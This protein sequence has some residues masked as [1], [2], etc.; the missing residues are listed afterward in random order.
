ML[1]IF[2]NLSIK[3]KLM[4]GFG[5]AILMLV[6]VSVITLLAFSR[7]E[8]KISVMVNDIQPAVAASTALNSSLHNAT[9]SMG[10]YLLSKEKIH[11]E[12]YQKHLNQVDKEF[13][14]LHDLHLISNTPEYKKAVDEVKINLEKF[15]AYKDEI[16]AITENPDKNIPALKLANDSVNPMARKVLELLAQM[17]DS[18]N[19]EEDEYGNRKDMKKTLY[20]MRY[21]FIRVVSDLRAFVAFKAASNKENSRLYLK[22]IDSGL[23]KL[24]GLE[25]V[26]TFEQEE[27]IVELTPLIKNYHTQLEKLYVIHES[28]KSYQD[29]YLIRAEI[30]PLVA[31]ID[32]QLG[33]LQTKL[34]RK[35]SD[36]GDKLLQNAA[37]INTFIMI[38]TL[39]GVVFVS[40]VAVFILISI[41]RP[42]RNVTDALKDI[43]EGEGDLTQQLAVSGKDEISCMSESFN[44]FV[45]KIH[46]AITDV[47][48]AVT[49][50]VNETSQMAHIMDSNSKGVEKQRIETDKVGHAMTAMLNTSKEMEGKTQSASD[51]AQQADTSAKQG[52]EIVG[53]TIHSIEHLAQ[54]VERATG[55][56]N[57]LGQDVESI[58]SVAE[59]IK[60]IAEQTN[61][62]ALNAAIEAARTGEQGRGFAVVAD[63]VRMLASKTQEST[64]EIQATIEKL[65]NASTLAVEAMQDS[66]Q[67]AV[68]TVG[69][70]KEANDTLGS[71]VD[72]VVT[73]KEMNLYIADASMNQ[74]KT[75]SEIN[76]NMDNIID[77]SENTA[78]GTQDVSNALKSLNEIADKLN[79][80]VGA[81]K[82]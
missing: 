68:K 58:S 1:K 31:K 29:R 17:I 24:N 38:I 8:D 27:A 6:I 78:K 32:K 80:L 76:D 46:S 71:I 75:S 60:S 82:I 19:E 30:A 54:G 57:K 63:E 62:L 61:L 15:E 2:S 72:A 56:I 21:S 39:V 42:L 67:Q 18:E 25:D 44:L 7:T 66:Q 22:Q 37:E 28:E 35:T 43:A 26:L 10:F 77:I 53:Q 47:S 69:H 59:V 45:H 79:T 55:V 73:I 4:F 16:I 13:K 65:Q 48:E 9:Q 49:S 74:S 41:N 52:Q 70:A 81:F 12:A 34:N 36:T 40:L 64:Q 3:Y 33:D 5:G 51:S 14:H 20:D 50:L 23:E 11:G